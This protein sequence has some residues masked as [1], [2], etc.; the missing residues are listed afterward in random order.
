[1]QAEKNKE[2]ELKR[3]KKACYNMKLIIND[4]RKKLVNEMRMNELLEKENKE[5]KNG[6]EHY[7]KIIESL[8]AEKKKLNDVIMQYENQNL[9]LMK[10]NQEQEKEIKRLKKLNDTLL[11]ENSYLQDNGKRY[12]L[13]NERMKRRLKE[14]GIDWS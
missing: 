1:V 10:E 13:E 7:N 4:L 2:R 3:Y 9:E 8:E 6:N 11:D 5:L 12:R 14:K